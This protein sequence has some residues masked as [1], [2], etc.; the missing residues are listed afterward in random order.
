MQELFTEAIIKAADQAI[1]SS[2][3]VVVFA[4]SF[5]V[6]ADPCETDRE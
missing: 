1:S 2:M 3:L 4:V 6:A 5:R